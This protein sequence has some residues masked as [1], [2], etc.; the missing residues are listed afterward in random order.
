MTRQ[1]SRQRPGTIL[2]RRFELY[3]YRKTGSVK[4]AEAARIKQ[5]REKVEPSS[6]HA[7]DLEDKFPRGNH[8]IQHACPKN[9]PRSS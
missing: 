3:H 4:A 7:P 6:S 9:V 8:Q 5:A 1:S 2:R